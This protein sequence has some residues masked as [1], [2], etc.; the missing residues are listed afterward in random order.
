MKPFR[1]LLILL[2]LTVLGLPA[3]AQSDG[4][5]EILWDTWGVP[6]IYADNNEDLFY[7]FGWAQM[8]NHAD[9]ILQLYGRS[10]GEAAAYWGQDLVESDVI[11]HTVGVPE[12]AQTQYEAQTDEFKSY[13]DAF[14]AGMNA[15]AE[16][17]PDVI[18]DGVQMVL[19]VRNTDP[20]A[21]AIN[22]IDVTF[23]GGAAI[24]LSQAWSAGQLG[25]NAWAIAP[26]KSASGNALLIENPHLPWS[27]LFTW[28]EAHLVA[29]DV[30]L[31]GATLVGLP[32][33]EI[34]F[35]EHLGWTHTVNTYDG[36]DLYELTLTES[37]GY[38]LDGEEQALEVREQTIDI[39]QADG[40]LAPYSFPVV[41]SMH[42][43]VI[44]QNEGGQALALRI[45]SD[46]TTHMME[47]WWRMGT[48][49]NLEQFEAAM[50]WLQIPMFNTVY[51]DVDGNIYY[52][53]NA[54][55]PK[56]ESGDYAGWQ[57]IQL[58][59]DSSLIWNEYHTYDELPK[60]IN[61]ETGF[62]QNANEP[63]WTSTNPPAIDFADYPPYF[64]PQSFYE[65]GHIFRPQVS[66][67][68]A[69]EDD[70]ITFEELLAY[71]HNT[72]VEATDH[73]L[74]D[75]IAAASAS[76]TEL[77]QQ[78]A[79]VLAAWDRATNADSQGALLFIN[80]FE[81]YAGQTG[82]DLFAT[83]F[84]ISEPYSTP[85]GLSDPDDAVTALVAVAEQVQAAYGALD[86]PYG[87]VM[88]LRVG[89]YDLPGNGGSDPSGVFRAAWY[90]PAGDGT[91]QIAGGD[92]W[93]AVIEFADPIRARVLVGQGNATQPGSPHVGD[94][95]ELFANQ[96]LREPWLTREAVE[97]NLEM[98]ETLRR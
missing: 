90:A 57:G 38:R 93:V 37:G 56:H 67:Q 55:I 54:I 75:L 92:S 17:N 65:T 47:Q 78:A 25:S 61:P 83:P 34:G 98:T 77:A 16:A 64:A 48:A 26:E 1:F 80:W 82:F 81:Q 43:P 41:K 73:V 58:G 91:Y 94:Q 96:E 30:N 46:Q 51:A 5:P 32:G 14:V 63:P 4:S 95:V 79:D 33:I 3:L 2:A 52:L 85:A 68:T 21:L 66:S 8:H 22:D 23:V 49:T 89:E 88:R 24:G 19:P 84:D 20:L 71:K 29:P 44:A 59:D 36:F 39:L 18:G 10:R 6:H 50:D 70:S 27:D 45:A 31:Y 53:D 13:L 62:V 42:G 15:Y 60:V 97:A 72:H 35:N 69:F 86:V 9:L 28:F 87:D 76:E 12:L 11:M 74:D 7:A 40:S